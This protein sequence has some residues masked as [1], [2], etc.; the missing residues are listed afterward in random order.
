MN[1]RDTPV[2]CQECGKTFIVTVEKQ[3]QMSE[4][5]LEVVIPDLCGAC[6]QRLKYGGKLHGRVKWFDLG[7]GYGF[8]LE[9]SGKELFFHRTSVPLSEDGTLPSLEEGQHVLYEAIESPKGPQAVQVAPYH[10]K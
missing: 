3:R 5:G 6:T 8:I 1:F 2:T 4:Q 9:D 10:E 7:K